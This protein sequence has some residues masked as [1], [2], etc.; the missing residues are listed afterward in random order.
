M[1]LY[2]DSNLLGFNLPV[3]RGHKRQR[4]RSVPAAVDISALQAPMTSFHVQQTPASYN[5]DSRIYA[6]VPQPVHALPTNLRID[7][8]NFGFDF[9]ANPMSATTA[10]SPSDFASPSIF[11]SAAQGDST[12]VASMAPQFNLSFM[13][14]APSN[15]PIGGSH[16]PS[17]YSGV[18]PADPLIANHSPPLSNM[19]HSSSDMY[20]FG[21]DQQ[22]VYV[23]DGLSATEM[24]PKHNTDYAVSHD[25]HSFDLPIHN[26][27]GHG[28]PVLGDYAHG[29]VN[30]DDINSHGLPSGS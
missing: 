19:P 2:Q 24:Y 28:T 30:L 6:P 13:S 4:S 25:A 8:G 18:S 9:N 14:V 26:L 3:A 20:G 16:A 29:L 27:S 12:P 23:E 1:N 17:P 15:S 10:A 11:S 21:H 22:S 7:T 5:P